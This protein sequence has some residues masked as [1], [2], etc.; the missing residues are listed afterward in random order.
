MNL[1]GPLS[2]FATTELPMLLDRLLK[3]PSDL[4]EVAARSYNHDNG[5]AKIILVDGAGRTPSLRL[6]AWAD[7]EDA[8]MGNIHN[9]CWNFS[10]YVISGSLAFEEYVQDP[11]GEILT[12]HLIYDPTS[13]FDYLLRPISA[14]A[15]R[16]TRRGVYDTG[17]GYDM[18]GETLHR[19]WAQSPTTVTLVRQEPRH[20]EHSDVFVL[21]EVETEVHDE[22]LTIEALAKY[23]RAIKSMLP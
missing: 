19:T 10:S 22:P 13:A 6:H 1:A 11:A 4:A 17:H 5:F 12:T 3:S 14:V 15:L 20:R 7:P 18:L 16:R 2:T 21:K 8:E 23:L 9:H